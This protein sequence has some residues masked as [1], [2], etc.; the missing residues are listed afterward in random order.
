M[1]RILLFLLI[2]SVVANV[3][4]AVYKFPPSTKT[5]P[6]SLIPVDNKKTAFPVDPSNPAIENVSVVYNFKGNVKQI[7]EIG[8]TLEIKLDVGDSTFPKFVTNPNTGV[9]RYSVADQTTPPTIASIKDVQPGSAVVLSTTYHLITNSWELSAILL[10][11][12]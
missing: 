10:L 3:L 5:S 11:P 8:T 9:F 7:T 6:L 1:S 2:A 4:L 12:R